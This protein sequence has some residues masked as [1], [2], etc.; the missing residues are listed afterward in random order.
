MTWAKVS[1][2]CI[3]SGPWRIFRYNRAD[4]E[5]FELWRGDEFNGRY[6]ASA[7]AKE[8]AEML[9]DEVA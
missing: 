1:E 2:L 9:W 3:A 6:E 7:K 4:P 8:A 5:Y